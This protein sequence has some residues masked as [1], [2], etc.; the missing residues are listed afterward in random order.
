MLAV[1]G[2]P[3]WGGIPPAKGEVCSVGLYMDPALLM[4]PRVAS[5]VYSTFSHLRQI[6]QLHPYLD[7]GSFTTLVQ[8]LVVS[9]L[10]F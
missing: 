1:L 4:E 2:N 8:A 5:V 6:A 7:T 3:L 10:D 9:K